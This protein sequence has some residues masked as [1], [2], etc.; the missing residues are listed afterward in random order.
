MERF[1]CKGGCG[2]YNVRVSKHS[3]EYLAWVIDKQL[4]VIS[5]T[6]I[7]ET[8]IPQSNLLHVLLCDQ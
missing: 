7:F 2:I 4:W 5:N 1:S 3:K 6:M 8:V